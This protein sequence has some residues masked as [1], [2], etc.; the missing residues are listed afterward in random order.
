MVSTTAIHHY[1]FMTRWNSKNLKNVTK[2]DRSSIALNPYQG[3]YGKQTFL[4]PLR[5]IVDKGEWRRF[6]RITPVTIFNAI[7]VS[8]GI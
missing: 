4:E 8:N 6:K 2:R 5:E 7:S 1:L 3:P